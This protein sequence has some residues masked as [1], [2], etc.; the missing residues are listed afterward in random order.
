M[1]ESPI[2]SFESLASIAPDFPVS[3]DGYQDAI[4]WLKHYEQ[5]YGPENVFPL[6]PYELKPIPVIQE[7]T[8]PYQASELIV[9]CGGVGAGKTTLANYTQQVL[10][11]EYGFNALLIASDN[12]SDILADIPPDVLPPDSKLDRKYRNYYGRVWQSLH[13]NDITIATAT[14]RTH[15]RRSELVNLALQAG[16][17]E[18]DITFVSVN[19]S[20]GK[21][22]ERLTARD[23]DRYH[24]TTPDY[25]SHRQLA[26][27]SRAEK[28]IS[29]K[30][31]YIPIGFTEVY[32]KGALTIVAR[33]DETYP[34]AT[35]IE[36][37]YNIETDEDGFAVAREFLEQTFIFP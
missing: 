35:A 37:N 1:P 5:I 19:A 15:N 12:G 27:S 23:D 17:T 8:P 16:L 21:R 32:T 3:R 34:Q 9:I 22:W 30:Y 4:R 10:R 20:P 25:P 13:A 33:T 2:P 6:F 14:H 18:N 11:V 7:T 28:D 26:L 31:P 24:E 29:W 36:N